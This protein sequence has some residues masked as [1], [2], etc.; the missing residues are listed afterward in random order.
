[1]FII[2]TKLINDPLID[3]NPKCEKDISSKELEFFPK[4]VRQATFF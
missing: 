3:P 4:C 1:M 2:I